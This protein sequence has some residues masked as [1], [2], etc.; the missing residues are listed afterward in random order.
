M[1]NPLKLVGLFPFSFQRENLGWLLVG[2]TFP[3]FLRW[4]P[5][6]KHRLVIFVGLPAE[7]T[8]RLGWGTKIR[9]S[10]EQ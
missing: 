1:L 7:I 5:W 10:R 8:S 3:D 6:T 4:A 2:P 9:F